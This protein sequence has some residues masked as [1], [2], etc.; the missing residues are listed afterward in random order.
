MSSHTLKRYR[1]RHEAIG[2]AYDRSV[3]DVEYEV[4]EQVARITI[5]R[6]DRRNAM[7]FDVMGMLCDRLEEVASDDSVHVVVLSGAGEKAFSAG[8]DLRSMGSDIGLVESHKARGRLAD[9]FRRLWSLEKP[10]IARVRGFALAGGFGLAMSCD[11]VVASSDAQFGTPEIDVG[12]WPYMI[13]VPLLRSMPQRFA[14]ELM[15]TGRRV[16]AEEAARVGFVNRVVPPDELD[17]SVDVLASQLAAKS[18]LILGWGKRSFYRT[19]E[20]G[21]DEAL[22]YLQGMLTIT[23]TSQDTAEGIAAFVEKRQPQWRGR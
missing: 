18:P 7:S 2:I 1:S 6:P 19:L 23:S 20:M 14:L 13:T 3:A 5:N 15:A 12:L 8:A 17:A 10:T 9:V 21:P 4:K 16:D 22:E 11:F